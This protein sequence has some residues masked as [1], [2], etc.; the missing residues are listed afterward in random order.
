[1]A[2]L[3]TADPRWRVADMGEAGKNVNA[4][5]WTEHDALAWTQ[6]RLAQLF[7]GASGASTS[8]APPPLATTAT[9]VA[10][11]AAGVRLCKGECQLN[12]R[13]GRLIVTYELEITVGW[14]AKSGEGDG[15]EASGAVEIP[16]FGDEHEDDAAPPAGIRVTVDGA[17]AAAAAGAATLGEAARAALLMPEAK[18]EVA[19][20]LRQLVAEL[21]QGAPL[22]KEGGGGGEQGPAGAAAKP[23]APAAAP[24]PKPTPNKPA[25]AAATPEDSNDT[26]SFELEQ[27]FHARAADLF[28]CFTVEGRM[29]AFTQSDCQLP[30]PPGSLGPFSWFSG[31]VEGRV[32]SSEP[33]KRLELEWRFRSWRE[34]CVSRVVLEFEEGGGGGR[35]GGEGGGKGGGA[36]LAV[37]LKQTGIPIEDGHG[38]IDQKL[39]VEQGWKERVFGRIRQVFGYGTGGF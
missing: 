11:Q 21:K 39:L 36:L 2:E 23:A 35:G 8:A 15:L 32:V 12:N 6:A 5:H 20:R 37:R 29:R 19:R 25:P 4:W 26:D 27:R 24:A 10:V 16:Y 22:K 14:T 18:Q 17:Q 38:N 34:G 30:A 31:G 9:G 1:M 33:N 3:T 7:D 28:E 13:K